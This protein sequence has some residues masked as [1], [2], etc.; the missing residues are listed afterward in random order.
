MTGRRRV[1]LMVAGVVVAAAVA[2]IAFRPSGDQPTATGAAPAFS[3]VDLAGRRVS[4]ADYRGTP[5]LLNFWASWCVPCR[6]EFP[7]FKGVEGKG[8][9]VVGVVFRDTN[10]AAAAFMMEQQATWP[11]LQDPGGRIADDYDVGFR[12]GLPVTILIDREGTLVERHV[13]ELR[14]EDLDRLLTLAA[15]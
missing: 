4:L 10:D 8:V 7:L 1:A 2:V 13:G 3:T 12:P 14:Q 5:V 6:K 9:E 11:A 15:A